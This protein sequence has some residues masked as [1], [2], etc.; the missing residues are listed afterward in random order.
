MTDIASPS[1][2]VFGYIHSFYR[3]TD[4]DKVAWFARVSLVVDKSIKRSPNEKPFVFQDAS[5]P[6]KG[7][8]YKL[9]EMHGSA[10]GAE[11]GWCKDENDKA[12]LYLFRIKGFRA[13]AD[14][15]GV[16]EPFKM[17]GRIVSIEDTRDDD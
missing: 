4:G 10:E 16:G 6:L 9:M 8:A 3:H 11:R 15:N 2:E 1:F 7:V 12:I 13:V 17:L 14:D 5:L